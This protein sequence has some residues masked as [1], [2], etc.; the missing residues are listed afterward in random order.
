MTAAI[1]DLIAGDAAL[2][3][4]ADVRAPDALDAFF[5]RAT[6]VQARRSTAVDDV[7]RADARAVFLLYMRLLSVLKQGNGEDAKR[8]EGSLL[9]QALHVT[10]VVPFCQLFAARNPDAVQELLNALVDTT[11]AFC[12]SLTPLRAVYCQVRGQ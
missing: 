8:S 3:L 6:S 1:A 2:A 9:A 5:T 4:E 12:G 11:P 7:F 10:R